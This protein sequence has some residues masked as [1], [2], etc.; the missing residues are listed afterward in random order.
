M[1]VTEV[2]PQQYSALFPEVPHVFNSVEFNSLNAC[3]CMA[4]HHLTFSNNKV[5]GGIILGESSDTLASPFSAP[6]GGFSFTRSQSI[7]YVDEMVNALVY[8]A[9]TCGK[10]LRVTLPPS[11][12]DESMSAKCVSA[13]SRLSDVSSIIDINY[14]LT[15]DSMPTSSGRRALRRSEKFDLAF[16][17]LDGTPSNI[18]RVYNVIAANHTHRHHPLHMSLADILATVSIVPA[19]FFVLTM[20]DTDV[21][22][23]MIYRSAPD[24]AQLIYW[25][26]TPGYS[27][28]RVMNRLAA[29]IHQHYRNKGITVIDLGISSLNGIPDAGLCRFKENIGAISLPRYTFIIDKIFFY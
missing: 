17:H 22:A 27:N 1:I 5:R 14:H 13:F 10:N 21:A 24:I 4:V 26:D 6:F 18:A 15:A 7:Q 16:H 9:I 20:G 11:F 2:T 23:A 3:K 12:Y 25:G 29:A 8:Y 19:D 28:M